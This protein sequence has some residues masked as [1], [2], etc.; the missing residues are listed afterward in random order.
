MAIDRLE[1]KFKLNQNKKPE[2]R[3]A[4]IEKLSSSSDTLELEVAK[5]MR[6]FYAQTSD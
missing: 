4:V 5:T 1:G 3:N 6:D 2:D